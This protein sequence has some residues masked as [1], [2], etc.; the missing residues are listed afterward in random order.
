VLHISASTKKESYLW[1]DAIVNRYLSLDPE[2]AQKISSFEGKVIAIEL[3]GIAK[4]F[5]LFPQAST[6]DARI[7]V[8]EDYEGEPDTLLKGTPAALFKMGL[9]SDVAPMMLKG[10]VEIMG[11]VRL[12]RE[13]KKLLAEMDVDWEEGLASLIGDVPAHHVTNVAKRFTSWANNAK[14][15]L[16]ADVSEY[17]QEESRDVVTGVELEMFYESVDELRND[18]DRLQARAD[19]IKK[20]AKG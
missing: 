9:A 11:D 15:S 3:L 10:E 8:S 2:M 19:A 6:E 18:V 5:Y 20:G 13:F 17:L 14:Q 16:V 12:G 7:K 1:I 4:T